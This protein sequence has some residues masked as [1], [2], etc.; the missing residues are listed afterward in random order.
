MI[1]PGQLTVRAGWLAG[2]L[3][4]ISVHLE[5][6]P[7]ARL[8]IGQT[9]GVVVKTVPY[10]YA[11]CGEAQR[12]VAARALAVAAGEPARAADDRPLW[13]ECLHEHLW[14]L[15]LDWPAAIG[16]APEREVFAAWRNQRHGDR[17][18]QETR[19]LID[20][21]LQPM[22][23]KCLAALVDRDTPAAAVPRLDP[24][25]WLAAWRSG[26]LPVPVRPRSLA[27][28]YRAR[29]A[30]VATAF[31]ALLA[32][33]PYPLAAAGGDGWGVAQAPTARGVLTHGVR[34]AAGR[35]ADYRVWAPTD[36]YFAD[37][38]ALSSLLADVA[39]PTRDMAEYRLTQAV[40]ALDPC[41]PHVV[42]LQ[43]A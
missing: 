23:E 24:A 41:V 21:V 1:G 43:D 28:A 40:L 9:P 4:E 5:R 29:L 35:V 16:E 27:A 31:A 34:L 11:L 39:C 37:A 12:A 7:A 32:E 14:R 19:Y 6:P 20:N 30:E 36:A 13:I 25:G 18:I 2:A 8:F 17:L 26:V 38:A 3:Q 15:L 42:E 10:L 33:H 22:S